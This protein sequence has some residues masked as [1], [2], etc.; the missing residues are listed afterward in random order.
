MCLG[1]GLAIGS[2]ASIVIDSDNLSSSGEEEHPGNQAAIDQPGSFA[3][4]PKR[5][6]RFYSGGHKMD[7]VAIR[8]AV[9]PAGQG[10]VEVLPG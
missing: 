8:Q 9:W 1:S 6:K 4:W 7:A 2:S 5:S 10:E 3:G